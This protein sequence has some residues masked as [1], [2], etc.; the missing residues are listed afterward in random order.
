MRDSR[1][2]AIRDGTILAASGEPRQADV[3]VRDGKIVEVGQVGSVAAEIDAGGDYLVP[4]LINSHMHSGENFNPG[5][6]ENLP[7]DVWFVHSHQVTRNAPPSPDVIYARTML[8]AI[9]MLRTGTTTTVDF[10]F[11]APEITIETLE[12][13]VQAYLDSGI[14]ATILLGVADLPYGDSLPLNESERE[15]WDQEAEA[16]SLARIMAVAEEAHRRWHSPDGRIGIGFGPSAPQRCSDELMF[17]SLEFCRSRG[18]AWQT[19]ILETKSQV[20]TARD[21]YGHS[22][23]TELDRRGMLGPATSLVHTVWLDDQDIRTIA[24]AKANAVHCLASN[25]RLGDGVAPVPAMREAGIRIGLGTD[26]R[27]CDE[28]MD[29]LELARWTASMH[30]ARGGDYHRWLTARDAFSMATREASICTGHGENLG[31]IEVGAHADL[32]IVDGKGT[33]FTP[34][35]DP[36]RQFVFGAGGRD[37]RNV[38]VDGH[39]VYEDGRLTQIDEA[40]MLAKARQA[41]AAEAAIL[42]GEATGASK[43]DRIVETAYLRIE[44]THLD[45]VN[46]YLPG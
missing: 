31:R 36:L 7:L 1:E 35:N 8:G 6:Y 19:H 27:G 32:L 40:E 13:I 28:T 22:F 37:I 17:K 25:M 11:E 39:V 42:S 26:G 12:P 44:D 15:A 3:L 38:I 29:M 14:R 21:R 41:A 16:P 45:G 46:A 43:L 5:L 18:L 34:L 10:V 4:G 20:W 2:F 9:Q 30:K 33:T 24:K 23:I